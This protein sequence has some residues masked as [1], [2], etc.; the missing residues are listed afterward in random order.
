MSSNYDLRVRHF[1]L[2]GGSHQVAR[3]GSALPHLARP[4]GVTHREI[5]VAIH[6][7]SWYNSCMI[8]RPQQLERLASLLKQNPI[9]AILGARQVGK[10]TLANELQKH[11]KLHLPGR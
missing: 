4:A 2:R 9:V 11:W 5:S 10:T 1:E 8:R 6:Q 3:S 7:I